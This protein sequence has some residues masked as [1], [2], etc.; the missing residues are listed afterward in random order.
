MVGRWLRTAEWVLAGSLNVSNEPI[1]LFEMLS[2]WKYC[3]ICIYCAGLSGR[4][5]SKGRHDQSESRLAKCGILALLAKYVTRR[6]VDETTHSTLNCNP[7]KLHI[8]TRA[9]ALMP[10]QWSGLLANLQ[11][12]I[13]G[14]L[15][16]STA[17]KAGKRK[18]CYRKLES[19]AAVVR[20]CTT[21][22]AERLAIQTDD[23]PIEVILEGVK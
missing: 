18:V 16:Y 8:C 2:N 22:Y 13:Q 10:G 4:S 5:E 23:G 7:P 12:M 3:H 11:R 1:G 15:S 20:S 17:I 14:G 19:C 9:E 6:R 21:S